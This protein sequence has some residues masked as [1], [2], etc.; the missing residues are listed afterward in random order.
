MTVHHEVGIGY[1]IGD[2]IGFVLTNRKGAWRD[3]PASKC[4]ML[5]ADQR[6]QLSHRQLQTFQSLCAAPWLSSNRPSPGCSRASRCFSLQTFVLWSDFSLIPNYPHEEVQVTMGAAI[7]AFIACPKFLNIFLR[8]VFAHLRALS[9][10]KAITCCHKI[11][12]L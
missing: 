1:P 10:A 12:I 6:P 9:Y 2:K 8:H 7:L 5:P 11:V 4:P 3:T